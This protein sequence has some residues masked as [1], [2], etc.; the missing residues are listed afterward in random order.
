MNET[1]QRELEYSPKFKDRVMQKE[2]DELI[3]RSAKYVS[4]TIQVQ[5]FVFKYVN[6]GALSVHRASR[7]T[8]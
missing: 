5:D 7:V 4:S 6:D 3:R 8:R 1:K 2:R